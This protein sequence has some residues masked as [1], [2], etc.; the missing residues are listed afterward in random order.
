LAAIYKIWQVLAPNQRQAIEKKA[1]TPQRLQD[2]FRLGKTKGIDR[3]IKPPDFDE[4]QWLAE[5]EKHLREKRP[6]LILEELRK[7]ADPRLPLIMRRMAINY[8][9]LDKKQQP[10]NSDHLATFVATFPPFIQSSF[11]QY[12]PDEARRRL[13]I[14]YRLVFPPGQ[15]IKLI[16][17]PSAPP[18]A[19]GPAPT[20]KSQ[21]QESPPDGKTEKKSG[22]SPF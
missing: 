19:A 10:V 16:P 17:A 18:G 4:D 6:T 9:Y 11:E 8:S 15:E 22:G 7:K 1:G 20:P 2:L 5:T 14:V 13:T 21:R 3:E 12:P